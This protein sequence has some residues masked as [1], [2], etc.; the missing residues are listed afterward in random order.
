LIVEK[1]NNQRLALHYKSAM[2]KTVNTIP[3]MGEINRRRITLVKLLG[4]F[5][6]MK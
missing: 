3:A 1:N 5:M 2:K 6:H 4:F